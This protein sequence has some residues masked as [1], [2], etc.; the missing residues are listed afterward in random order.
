VYSGSGTEDQAPVELGGWRL[1]EL[2]GRGGMGEVWRAEREGPGGIRRRA[3]LKRMLT[4]LRNDGELLQRFM[5]EARISSRLEHPNI[6]SLIDFGEQPEPYLVFEYVEG[7]SVA[8]LLQEASQARMKIP[9]VAAAFV[10]AEVASGLDYAHRKRDEHG[11]PLEI[12][13]R[14][15]SP[16]NVLISVEGAVKL[17]D[18]GVARAVDNTLRTRA[19]V[20]VGKLFYMAPEQAAGAP[21]DGRADVFSLG[22]VLWEMLTLQPLFPRSDP[23]TTLKR[24]QSGDIP[25]PS[26]IE[27]RIPAALDQIVR[28]ALATD[29]E[30]RFSSAAAFAQALRSFIHTL[31]PGFDSGELIKILRKIAPSV[32]WHIATPPRVDAG[33]VQ[34]GHTPR[35]VALALPAV[36]MPGIDTPSVRPQDSSLPP[37][38]ASLVPAVAPV[39]LPTAPSAP[40][41]AA[42][43]VSIASPSGQSH[44]GPRIVDPGPPSPSKHGVVVPARPS[45]S[46]APVLLAVLIGVI[47]ATGLLIAALLYFQRS[48]QEITSYGDGSSAAPV[49]STSTLPRQ[50]PTIAPVIGPTNALVMSEPTDVIPS[51]ATSSI[52]SPV[53]MLALPSKVDAGRSDPGASVSSS[54]HRESAAVLRLFSLHESEFVSCVSAPSGTRARISL[55]V[56]WDGAA[57]VVRFVESQSEQLT[58]SLDAQQ[59]LKSVAQRL[60]ASSSVGSTLT[61]HWSFWVQTRTVVGFEHGTR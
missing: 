46:N 34:A 11:R 13:H 45:F 50:V 6:V 25:A 48:S 19:G 17:G 39:A 55:R 22:V 56:Q 20:H 10:C 32:S 52:A 5:A 49:G 15:V 57:R 23:A 28:T 27:A 18:F 44:D 21:I 37:Q 30:C 38:Q 16:H 43:A 41:S 51:D 33:R 2:L 60:L 59:C 24:L 8:E 14:D 26:T 53:S 3:A 42:H 7:I 47:V 4:R 54:S 58:L 35:P 29:R 61:V 36:A 40:Y 9:A 12:V 31:A 1:V